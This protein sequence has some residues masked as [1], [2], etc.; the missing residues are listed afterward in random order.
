MEGLSGACPWNI[1]PRKSHALRPFTVNAAQTTLL[2]FQGFTPPID[3][4]CEYAFHIGLVQKQ[5]AAYHYVQITAI[6]QTGAASGT[7]AQVTRTQHNSVNMY[8]PYYIAGM[9]AW[10]AGV[11]QGVWLSTAI[12]GGTWAYYQGNNALQCTVKVWPR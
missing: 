5:D 10:S 4:W 7:G 8:E 1:A 3:C 9:L 6:L 11:A 2:G 12:S